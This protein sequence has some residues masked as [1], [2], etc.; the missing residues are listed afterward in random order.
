MWEYEVSQKESEEIKSESVGDDNGRIEDLSCTVN[1]CRN[2]DQ[3]PERSLPAYIPEAVLIDLLYKYD[4]KRE[5]PQHLKIPKNS[6][7]AQD[8]RDH[9]S[10]KRHVGIVCNAW[11]RN[12][13]PS[14]NELECDKSDR[15][16][17]KQLCRSALNEF[18]AGMLIQCISCAC[19]RYDKEE[20][21]EPRINDVLI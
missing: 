2:K 11:K 8:A 5:D 12:V 13:D 1:K 3:Y 20:Q 21:H 17:N 18:L 14:L 10:Y 6:D 9:L 16:R 7:T 19:S 4:N 15:N